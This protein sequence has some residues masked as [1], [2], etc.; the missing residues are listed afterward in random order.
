MPR[1]TPE[2]RADALGGS[3]P[4][5][6][7]LSA[8]AEAA[9]RKVST[10]TLTVQ[11]RRHGI[12]NAFIAGLRPARPDLRLLG[13]AFTLRY[14]PLREDVVAADTRELNAQ[15]EAVETIGPGEAL[16]IEARGEAGAGTIG[17][18]LALRALRR[19]AT[20]IVTDGSLRDSAAVARLDMPTYYLAPHA[21]VLGMRHYPLATNIPVACGGVLVMPGDVLVGDEDGVIVLPAA[22]AE[23]VALD[24]F[25]QEVREEFALERVDA[26]ESVRG[27][28]R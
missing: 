3:A 13:R 27:C 17:D 16:V 24:A 6:A 26:G 2:I 14:V 18:I 11:L 25:E 19:G 21:A 5:P 4:R 22:L 20:G 1:V 8:D 23:T 10:A 12:T 15:K 9:L 28:T 7:E